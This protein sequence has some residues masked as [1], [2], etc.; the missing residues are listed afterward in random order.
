MLVLAFACRAP[1]SSE[2]DSTGT[3]TNPT[4]SESGDGDLGSD[5][6]PPIPT[7]QSP[8]DGATELPLE[9]EL[10]WN[11]VEDPDGEPIRYRVYIDDT[12]LSEGLLGEEEGWAG[13][14]VGPLLFAHE[15]TYT[16]Q[17]ESPRDG[18]TVIAPAPPPVPAIVLRRASPPPQPAAPTPV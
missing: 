16:W 10:C 7:L 15:R 3:D 18:Q 14:C 13:P 1:T 4:S 5:E 9:L 2:G 11:L 8:E 12:V 6:L 17:V